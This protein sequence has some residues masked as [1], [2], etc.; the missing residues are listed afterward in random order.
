[1]KKICKSSHI[2]NYQ[3]GLGHKTPRKKN[4]WIF[5]KLK[6]ANKNRRFMN[7]TKRNLELHQQIL[8]L[9]HQINRKH[10]SD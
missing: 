10:L 4:S 7:V 6:I 1:M 8:E 5:L 2:L 3:K 9:H